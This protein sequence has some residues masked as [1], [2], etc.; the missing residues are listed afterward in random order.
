MTF[1][2]FGI[3]MIG[4]CLASRFREAIEKDFSL[5]LFVQEKSSGTPWLGKG[6][7]LNDCH[8]TDYHCDRNTSSDCLRP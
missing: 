8:N 7:F 4:Y 1:L 5:G 2:N 6:I 3:R